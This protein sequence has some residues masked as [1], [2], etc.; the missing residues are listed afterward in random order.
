MITG[1]D[2]IDLGYK[3]RKW[4]GEALIHANENQLTGQDLIGYL[5]TV[6]PTFLE[7]RR[8]IEKNSCS[9]RM[10]YSAWIR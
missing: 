9:N 2:I 3:P 4:L 5:D 7:P 6:H 10:G 1:K 8:K